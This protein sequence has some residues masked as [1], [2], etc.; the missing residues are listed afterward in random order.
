MKLFKIGSFGND[1]KVAYSTAGERV[2]VPT[3][4]RENAKVGDYAVVTTKTFTSRT[5]D[6]GTIV[7]CDPWDREDITFVGTFKECVGAKNETAIMELAEKAIT[8]TLA[9]ETAVALGVEEAELA[10]AF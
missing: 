6:D 3:R 1:N 10:S 7:A 2:F 5:D 9:K 4:F 8:K